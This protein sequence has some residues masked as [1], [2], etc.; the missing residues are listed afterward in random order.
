MS[1]TFT[2]PDVWPFSRFNKSDEVEH[3]QEEM[4]PSPQPQ[5]PTIDEQALRKEPMQPAPSVRRSETMDFDLPQNKAKRAAKELPQTTEQPAPA[6]EIKA[7][8]PI[9]VSDDKMQDPISQ[10]LFDKGKG[11]PKKDKLME[12]SKNGKHYRIKADTFKGQ[13]TFQKWLHANG[14]YRTNQ[15]LEKAK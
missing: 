3:E 5:P 1:G 6:A 13:P 15:E 8:D 11:H 2:W 14:Y 7:P 9:T 4:P 10:E 12:S